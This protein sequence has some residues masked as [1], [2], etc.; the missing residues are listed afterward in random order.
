MGSLLSLGGSVG[1]PRRGRGGL[2]SLARMRSALRREEDPVPVR[3]FNSCGLWLLV[4]RVRLG[5]AL[6]RRPRP[7]PGTNCK[8]NG[9]RNCFH[10]NIV[11]APV[12]RSVWFGLADGSCRCC[13]KPRNCVL[14]SP[15]NIMPSTETLPKVHY[16]SF[17]KNVNSML[18]QTLHGLN[19][20]RTAPKTAAG[21][22]PA[23]SEKTANTPASPE[24]GLG[25]RDPAPGA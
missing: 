21:A 16:E 17:A 24:L 22:L 5:P 3:H 9:L 12:F 6:F 18:N 11:P 10:A 8:R 15:E 7:K 19:F 13:F 25:A 1:A 2:C 23:P 20:C 14:G 4:S